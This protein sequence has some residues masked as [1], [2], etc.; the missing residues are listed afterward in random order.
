MGIRKV[1]KTIMGKKQMNQLISMYKK[2][3]KKHFM[4]A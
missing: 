4:K 2:K 3:K 1:E